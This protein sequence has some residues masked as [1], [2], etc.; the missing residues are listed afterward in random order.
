MSR[1]F[2]N[3]TRCGECIANV[4]DVGLDLKNKHLKRLVEK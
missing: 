1:P 4:D 3:N 2:F